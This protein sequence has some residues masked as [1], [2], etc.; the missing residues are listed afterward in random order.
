MS[1]VITDEAVAA[2]EKE[3]ETKMA[4]DTKKANDEFDAKVQAEVEK[5]LKEQADKAA[6]EAEEANK[7]KK[8]EDEQ[9]AKEAELEAMKVKQ[10][11]LEKQIE[12]ISARK[13]MPNVPT[14]EP[15]KP[16]ELTDADKIA[17]NKEWASG[18][19]GLPL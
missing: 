9:K 18:V 12:A 1:D 10:A 2:V 19:I 7:A 17:A 13:S 11:E 16:K 4:E 8:A 5:R 14:G 15:Q 6:K 3:I